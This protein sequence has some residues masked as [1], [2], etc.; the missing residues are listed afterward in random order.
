[1]IYKK[2]GIE[3]QLNIANR[4]KETCKPKLVDALLQEAKV[5]SKISRSQA[6]GLFGVLELLYPGIL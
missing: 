6:I 2:S 1:L 4:R 3:C 5:Q